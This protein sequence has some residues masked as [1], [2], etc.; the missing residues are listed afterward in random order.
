MQPVFTTFT[1]S[2]TSLVINWE[3]LVTISETGHTDILLYNLW[4]DVSLGSVNVNLYE[5]LT[6]SYT[7]Y[8]LV[9]GTTYNFQIRA[10]N[11]YGYGAF[12][13]I[14]S[15]TPAAVPGTMSAIVTSLVYPQV[16]FSFTAPFDNGNAITGYQVLIYSMATS[17]F[18]ERSDLCDGISAS[19]LASLSCSISMSDLMTQ[20]GYV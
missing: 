8:S 5:G 12:S 6:T 18:I 14:A 17:E 20:F 4:W 9:P 7:V 15:L 10:K 19:V 1:P 2:S 16:T 13:T 11:V 3:S